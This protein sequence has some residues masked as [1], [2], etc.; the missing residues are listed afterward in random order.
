MKIRIHT[1]GLLFVICMICLASHA[2]A[3]RPSQANY[4]DNIVT[5]TVDAF[6]IGTFSVDH[7]MQW[8][9]VSDRN[10]SLERSPLLKGESR[11]DYTYHER[12]L[13]YEGT[14][15]YI[16]D[17]S[18]NG[19]NVQ[20]GI[21]NLNVNHVIDFDGNSEKNGILLFGEMARMD[22]AGASGDPADSVRCIFASGSNGDGAFKGY[23]TVGSQMNVQEVS[24]RT[25]IGSSGISNNKDT[26]VNLRYTFDA[27]G[28][29]TDPKDNLATGSATVYSVV[30]MHTYDD[31]YDGP[32][33]IN[34]TGHF[35]DRQDQSMHGLFDLA[36]TFEYTN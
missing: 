19:G 5:S 15:T 11:T 9:Q 32:G 4:G 24:A 29:Q 34:V 7:E 17:F 28:L 10:G 14:A 3:V 18:M 23:V 26:P 16:K 22:V 30:D 35:R 6:C 25:S 12:T 2:V 13:G 31:D 8:G 21:D 1:M 36:T 20:P 33:P 27:E